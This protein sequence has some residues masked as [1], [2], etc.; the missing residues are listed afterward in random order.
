MRK[1]CAS[2][3]SQGSRVLCVFDRIVHQTRVAGRKTGLVLMTGRGLRH[4]AALALMGW[5]LM[6][7]PP[8]A[9]L[10]HDAPVKGR[11]I[12][13]KQDS[14]CPGVSRCLNGG[15]CMRVNMWCKS[16]AECKYSETC[17][18]SKGEWRRNPSGLHFE[19]GVCVP[20]KPN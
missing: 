19:N 16:D 20:R 18:L 7:I 8:A 11:Q 6:A 9:Q 15:I 2:S 13:C 14:D 1:I 4:T 17:D 3:H 12:L 5:Y 10:A